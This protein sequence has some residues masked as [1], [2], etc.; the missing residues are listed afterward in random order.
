MT[1]LLTPEQV[2][3]DLGNFS[4]FTIRRKCRQG[5]VEYT[6]GPRGKFLFTPDQVDALVAS[7]AVKPKPVTVPDDEEVI[8]FNTIGRKRA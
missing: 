5:L 1:H 7:L 8:G 3:A 4:P 6:Q 2:A